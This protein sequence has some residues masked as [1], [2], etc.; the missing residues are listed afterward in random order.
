[1]AAMRIRPLPIIVFGIG[2]WAATIVPAMVNHHFG[3]GR[4]ITGP[5]LEFGLEVSAFLAVAATCGYALVQRT[6]VLR[7]IC[8][9]PIA[10]AL[11]YLIPSR[12]A[13]WLSESFRSVWVNSVTMALIFALVGVAAGWL[14]KRYM[15]WRV[16]HA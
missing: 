9:V 7:A 8:A 13:I 1:M 12:F 5:E 4:P 11:L 15:Y 6:T 2:I 10:V 16:G 14:V 3:I